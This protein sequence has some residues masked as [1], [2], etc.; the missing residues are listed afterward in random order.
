MQIPIGSL[1]SNEIIR[2]FKEISILQPNNVIIN[3]LKINKSDNFI[4]MENPFPIK[5]NH[6]KFLIEQFLKFFNPKETIDLDKEKLMTYLFEYTIP[7]LYKYIYSFVYLK[8][9]N[10]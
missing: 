5:E 2:L 3:R 6:T 1:F 9:E 10:K 7:C 4:L 8:D